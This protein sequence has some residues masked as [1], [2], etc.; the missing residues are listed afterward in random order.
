MEQR[1]QAAEIVGFQQVVELS[2]VRLPARGIP[3]HPI[4][5]ALVQALP[6][7]QVGVAQSIVGSAAAPLGAVNGQV[8]GLKQQRLSG[9]V[10]D[11]KLRQQ[12]LAA[13]HVT[14]CEGT[15]APLEQRLDQERRRTRLKPMRF[16]LAAVEQQQDVEG[17]V[18]LL[19]AP[20]FG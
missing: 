1:L 11:I 4:Q 18:H 3:R 5:Q 7:L 14:Q 20:R 2:T 16:E 6:D 19:V 10:I 12:L 9:D 15:N 17:I 13:D 8:A